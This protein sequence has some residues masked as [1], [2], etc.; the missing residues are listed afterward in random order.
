MSIDAYVQ[1]LAK[2]LAVSISIIRKLAVVFLL[3]E[4]QKF[5]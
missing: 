5:Y 3:V 1:W 4:I 2:K